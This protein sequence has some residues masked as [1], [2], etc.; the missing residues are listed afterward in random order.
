MRAAR[1]EL[2]RPRDAEYSNNT[3][4]PNVLNKSKLCLTRKPTER[5]SLDVV[6]L[7]LSITSSWGNGHAVTYRGLMEEL[8]RRGHQVLFLERN[9]PW[10]ADHRDLPRSRYGRIELYSDLNELRKSYSERIRSADCVIVGS[11]VPDGIAVGE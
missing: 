2:G 5:A 8:I 6:I 7:G 10:Y 11:Y 1:S 4:M 9:V 3:L